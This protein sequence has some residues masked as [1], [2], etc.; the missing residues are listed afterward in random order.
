MVWTVA[1]AVF[2]GGLATDHHKTRSRGGRAL[3][4]GATVSIT[5][6]CCRTRVSLPAP[7]VA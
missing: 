5:A 6:M 7:S 1:A 2:G 4:I 3:N